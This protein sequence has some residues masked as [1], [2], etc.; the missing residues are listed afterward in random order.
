MGLHFQSFCRLKRG[1]RREALK[2]FFHGSCR[3]MRKVRVSMVALIFVVVCIV[4]KTSLSCDYDEVMRRRRT[5]R[6]RKKKRIIEVKRLMKK[7]KI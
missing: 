4:I 5:R 6:E 2:C 3:V 1:R 7:W